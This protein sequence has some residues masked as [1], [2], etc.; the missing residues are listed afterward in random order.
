MTAPSSSASIK[1]SNDPHY[2]YNADTGEWGNLLEAGIVDPVKVTR[3]ALQNAASVA[4]LLLTTEALIAEPPKKK[5]PAGH[6]P[7]AGG[8][9]GGMGGMG[10]WR[11][12]AW[13]A[14][15]TWE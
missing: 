13:A 12:V 1:K 2:G 5:E 14:W 3:M 15:V 4:G 8:G 7:H 10:G 6:D 9:M 11:W